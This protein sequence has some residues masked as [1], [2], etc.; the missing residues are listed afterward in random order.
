M[1]CILLKPFNQ[2][3]IPT[4]HKTPSSYMYNIH[5]RDSFDYT[6]V[7]QDSLVEADVEH[8][9]KLTTMTNVHQT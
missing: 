9:I 5:L 4:T 6:E 3:T 7:P 8:K 2:T 1:L